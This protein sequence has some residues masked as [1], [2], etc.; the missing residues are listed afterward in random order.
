MC[1]DIHFLKNATFGM[2]IMGIFQIQNQP[3]ENRLHVQDIVGSLIANRL[4]GIHGY[5]AAPANHL[6]FFLIGQKIGL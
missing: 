2:S 4:E 3:P 5:I 1:N 6:L